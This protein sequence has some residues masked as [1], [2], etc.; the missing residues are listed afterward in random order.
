MKPKP[1]MC[2]PPQTEQYVNVIMRP[3]KQHINVK[4]SRTK[5]TLTT[6]HEAGVNLWTI[7]CWDHNTRE[8]QTDRKK[9]HQIKQAGWKL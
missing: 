9:E 6:I 4:I 5:E 2:S 3:P 8:R 7:C 1:K